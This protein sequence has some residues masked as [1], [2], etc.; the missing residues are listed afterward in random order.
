MKRTILVLVFVLVLLSTVCSVAFANSIPL[1]SSLLPQG[2]KSV[3]EA[4]LVVRFYGDA[5]T[6]SSLEF[7]AWN[8]F[9][10]GG[11]FTDGTNI[12]KISELFNKEGYKWTKDGD[13]YCLVKE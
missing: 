3:G 5:E 7:T 1:R 13:N 4:D 2:S 8:V 6:T 12:V 10:G 9:W 11:C